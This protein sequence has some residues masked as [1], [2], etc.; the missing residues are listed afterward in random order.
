MTHRVITAKSYVLADKP[1]ASSL[2]SSSVLTD[3]HKNFR[4]TDRRRQILENQVPRG[5]ANDVHYSALASLAAKDG[6][7]VHRGVWSLFGKPYSANGVPNLELGEQRNF[8]QQAKE[9]RN[10]VQSNLNNLGMV[11]DDDGIRI[12]IQQGEK[13][14]ENEMRVKGKIKKKQVWKK[15][16]DD[17]DY[18][19]PREPLLNSAFR[20]KKSKNGIPE[21]LLIDNLEE[22]SFREN[23]V[24]NEED[25]SKVFLTSV[26]HLMQRTASGSRGGIRF[27]GDVK[28]TS[29]I[30]PLLPK[31]IASLI[32]NM[33]LPMTLSD[34]PLDPQRQVKAKSMYESLESK[35]LNK[36]EQ[37]RTNTRTANA[38][39]NSSS[40][41]NFLGLRSEEKSE[42]NL[43]PYTEVIERAANYLENHPVHR[44]HH[45]FVLNQHELKLK[46]KKQIE[47]REQQRIRVMSDT[48]LMASAAAIIIKRVDGVGDVDDQ[49]QKVTLKTSVWFAFCRVR[50]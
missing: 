26:P 9:R 18:L 21:T 39:L 41:S 34:L 2:D 32:R 6:E 20:I 28:M 42:Q 37:V 40:S 13:E 27:S 48:K 30:N 11:R 45:E 46:L 29:E 44:I 35:L 24:F 47:D 23:E 17:E 50:I 5:S 38:N 36:D 3:L 7:R 1:S 33:D 22:K 43:N 8:V 10:L 4:V 19:F 12:T 49:S 16:V 25:R 15:I 31:I 14:V